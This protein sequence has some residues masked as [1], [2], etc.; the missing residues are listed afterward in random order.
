MIGSYDLSGSYGY[1]GKIDHQDVI[2]GA[3]KVIKACEKYNKSCGTQLSK[4]N[5]DNVNE[6]FAQGYTFVILSSD[7]FVLADWSNNIKKLINKY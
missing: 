2:K 5:K 3:K 4:V 1:P 7:L 6:S